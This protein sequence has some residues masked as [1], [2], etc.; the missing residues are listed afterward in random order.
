MV[1]NDVVKKTKYNKLVT[2]VDNIDTTNFKKKNKYENDGSDFEDKISKIDKKIPDVTNLVKKTD[3]NTKV[4]EIEGQIPDV[5]SLVT[6]SALTVVENK[7]PDGS[8]FVK[9]AD[10]N[11]KVTEIEGKIPDVSSL[12]KKKQTML[13]K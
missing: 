2:K 13:Q 10:F 4:T 6:K 11:T 7:I 9:K 3:F 1:K 8:S 12:V 5:S